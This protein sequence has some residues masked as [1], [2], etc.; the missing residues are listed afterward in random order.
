MA[1]SRDRLALTL[2]VLALAGLA[3]GCSSNNSN[4]DTIVVNGL[5]CGLVRADLAGD[6]SVSYLTSSA[7]LQNCDDPS[8]N[9]V[10]VDVN[11]AVTT[12][13]NGV[14]S[15]PGAAGATFS[16]VGSG[17]DLPNE[18]QAG[19]QADSCLSLVQLWENDD[20]GWV[21]C[22][23]GLDLTANAISAVCDAID[24]DTNADG[25]ADTVCDLSH[26]FTATITT[27]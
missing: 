11:G 9:G 24:L 13:Y 1:R 3:S 5:D 7:T 22:V 10:M 2:G 6:W 27:P 19:V 21:Q 26:S 17:P 8:K 18:L 15:F 4:G 25:V 20:H 16:A 12:I 14:V 23:G